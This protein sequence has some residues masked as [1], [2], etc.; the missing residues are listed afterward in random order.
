MT[1]FAFSLALLAP[2]LVFAH[3]GHGSSGTHWHATDSFGFV[4]VAV[5]AA[6]AIWFGRKK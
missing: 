3:E 6:V 4:L 2:T 5:L 1:R